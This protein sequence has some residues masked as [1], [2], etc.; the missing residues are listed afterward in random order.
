MCG[1]NHFVNYFKNEGRSKISLQKV[2]KKIQ[3][4]FSEEEWNYLKKYHKKSKT[5]SKKSSTLSHM[6]IEEDKEPHE[7]LSLHSG[8]KRSLNSSFKSG[9][10]SNRN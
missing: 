5:N 1:Y 2:I 10:S 6:S 9:C 8:S 4:R 3:K 7:T